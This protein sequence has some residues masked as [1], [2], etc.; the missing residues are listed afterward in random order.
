MKEKIRKISEIACYR[1]RPGI[2]I[3]GNQ[4]KESGFDYDTSVNVIYEKDKITITKIHN[5]EKENL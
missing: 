3:A 2:I 4:V 5:H 1:H